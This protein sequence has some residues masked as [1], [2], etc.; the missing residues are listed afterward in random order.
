ME[1]TKEW[2][3]QRYAGGKHDSKNEYVAVPEYSELMAFP[4]MRA[5][6][7]ELGVIHPSSE[8]RGHNVKN[9]RK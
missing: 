8:F 7:D 3:I 6:L 4:E 2:I 1:Q 9:E 5:A